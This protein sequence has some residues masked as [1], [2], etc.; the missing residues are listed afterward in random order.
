MEQ[1]QLREKNNASATSTMGYRL[2]E[3]LIVSN[4]MCVKKPK[5]IKFEELFPEF[6]DDNNTSNKE[7][8]IE[9]RWREFLGVVK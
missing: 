8:Q 7:E 6:K 3:M 1:Q 9:R 4:G 5:I 2:A